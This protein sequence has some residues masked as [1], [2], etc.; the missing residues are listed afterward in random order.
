MMAKR[1]CYNNV[2][3]VYLHVSIKIYLRKLIGKQVPM[4]C[5][6]YEVNGCLGLSNFFFQK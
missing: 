5:C 6:Y 3:Y 4:S 1:P 2:I